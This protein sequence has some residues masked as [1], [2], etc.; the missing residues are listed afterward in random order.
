MSGSTLRWEPP[1]AH[2]SE[3]IIAAATPQSKINLT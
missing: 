2:L 1:S 3:L